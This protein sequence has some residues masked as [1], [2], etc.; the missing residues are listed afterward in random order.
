MQMCC[1]GMEHCWKEKQDTGLAASGEGSRG[2][3]R[4]GKEGFFRNTL[5]HIVNSVV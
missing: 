2:G 5:W 4:L 1:F 3:G